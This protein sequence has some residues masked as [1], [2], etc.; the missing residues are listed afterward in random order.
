MAITTAVT[1]G[2]LEAGDHFSW[3]D[4]LRS[5]MAST[6]ESQDAHDAILVYLQS[7]HGTPQGTYLQA[8]ISVAKESYRASFHRPSCEKFD[9]RRS[10]YLVSL[11]FAVYTLTGIGYGD[12]N[13]VTRAE[14]CLATACVMSTAILWAFL[15]GNFCAMRFG[16]A[17]GNAAAR[18]MQSALQWPLKLQ[19]QRRSVSCGRSKWQWQ[20][21][22]PC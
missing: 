8:A 9:T 1:M 20:G 5:G 16:A 13:A 17:C 3:V 11:Y 21:R 18:C 4:A 14:Y 10:K 6:C 2:E 7:H 19:W 15:I 12:V 22:E